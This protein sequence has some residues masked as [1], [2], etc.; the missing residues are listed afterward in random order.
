M[1]LTF[2][3]YL[4][5]CFLLLFLGGTKAYAFSTTTLSDSL[6]VRKDSG[7]IPSSKQATDSVRWMRR[8][9]PSVL[10]KEKAA[11]GGSFL[12]RFNEIDTSYIEPQKYN[13]AFMIQNTNT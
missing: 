1:K 4:V 2:N 5:L 9:E 11:K 13:F 3:D 12:Q 7:D 10:S 8:T 6:V